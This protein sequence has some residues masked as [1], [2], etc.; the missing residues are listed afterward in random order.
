MK[1]GGLGW[2]CRW[3]RIGDRLPDFSAETTFGPIQFSEW[4][5]KAKW[6][7]LLVSHPADFTPVCTTELAELG[8]LV[9]E[10][11]KRGVQPI[12]LSCDKLAK[13]EKWEKDVLEFGKLPGDKLPYPVIADADRSIAKK[14]DMI[15]PERNLDD[16]LPQT[17][18]SV[19]LVDKNLQLRLLMT[20][21]ASTGRVWSEVLRAID[22]I[23]LADKHPVG[24]VQFFT[25]VA[26]HVATP[27]GWTPGQKVVVVPGMKTEEAKK[28]YPEIE[29][30]KP[31]LRFI[32]QPN[33]E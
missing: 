9:K 11:E 22:S 18:R 27:H 33:T 13:H 7:A 32:P 26:D 30:I 10:F 16:G 31:Y 4:V 21:P 1:V 6:G 19:F 20:Y 12:G 15:D 8:K 24:K 14:Y 2:Q 28:K 17:V 25:R 23:Q 3:F 5:G 29:V